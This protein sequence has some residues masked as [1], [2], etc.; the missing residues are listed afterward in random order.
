MSGVD[1]GL[2]GAWRVA[3][4][5]MSLAVLPAGP[6]RAQPSE[7]VYR[8]LAA[9]PATQV[10]NDPT[11]IASGHGAIFV[12]AM[13]D[14]G[15]E[16]AALVLRGDEVVASGVNGVRIG[17]EPGDYVV[18]VGSA[19]T[20]QM[21]ATPVSVVAGRTSILSVA[22][23]GLRVEV[24]D[25]SN[26]PHRAG[27][28]LIR[29]ADRQPYTVAFGADTLQGERLLTLL[30]PPG[31]YRIVQP[32][33]TYRARTDFATVLVPAGGL[34]H[35]K[36]V[37][38]P[39]SGQF[40]GAGVVPPEELGVVPIES[41]WSRRYTIGLSVP[42]T[43]TANVIGENN[44]TKF[45][46]ET[47]FDAY[48]AYQRDQHLFNVVFELEA[49]FEKLKPEGSP[50]VPW[51]KTRDRLRADLLY[52]RFISPRVGPYVRAGLRTSVF[53]SNTL[54]TEDTVIARLFADGRRETEFVGANTTF[55]TG[56]PFSPPV[57]REGVGLNTRVLQRRALRMDWRAGV[58]FRQNRFAGAF[59]LEDDP[60]TPEV[61]YVQ[62]NNINQEGLEMTVV[63]TARYRF[64]LYNTTL[65]LFGDF[66]DHDPTV[67][68][69]ST[70]SWRLTGD[71]S[72][73]YKVDLLRVP[74]VSDANQVGQS[75]LFRY[76]IGS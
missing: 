9:D 67:D 16:P 51:R 55:P 38:D 36:L 1:R 72:L 71:L 50:A 17:V 28:E 21:V 15:S 52:A 11:P 68:W 2:G 48:V 44:E 37:I 14:G 57:F 76:S 53:E 69:R 75:V 3:W 41:P 42:F 29:V 33:S 25:E 20:S 62:A 40:R 12:P 56:D 22:W 6:A 47:F 43:S 59:F 64:L 74:Q 58:G 66:T 39:E 7:E 73:D 27:Y 8:W 45:G 63:A 31:L 54:V 13:T 4:V 5:V 49:G 65:D 34:V 19:P 70:L 46:T 18:R 24:V 35:Y 10:A 61:E 26:L 60:L 32:G 23:G 30:L